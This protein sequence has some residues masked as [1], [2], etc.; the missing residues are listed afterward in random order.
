FQ[1]R[2]WNDIEF[3]LPE[4]VTR[5]RLLP[6][7]SRIAACE[8]LDVAPMRLNGTI[9]YVLIVRV[10]PRGGVGEVISLPLA[11]IPTDQIDQLLMPREAAWFA[12]ISGPEPGA[13]CDALAVPGCCRALLR[14]ILTG[15]LQ[16]ADGGAI[17]AVPVESETPATGEPIADWPLMVSLNNRFD[18]TIMFGEAYVFKAFHRIEEGVNPD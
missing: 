3:L 4:Y 7:R 11:F 2:N 17:E 13:L 9:I 10:D 8:I 1:P 12:G 5:H 15:R 14:E 16:E 6:S 18:T